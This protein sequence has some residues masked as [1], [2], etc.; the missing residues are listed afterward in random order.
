[1][2]VAG[3]LHVVLFGSAALL[4][5]VYGD[6]AAAAGQFAEGYA[7]LY[8]EGSYLDQV[9]FRFENFAA[10]RIEAFGVIP[11]STFLFLLG[12]RLMRSGAFSSDERG[13]RI[14]SRLL[15]W[16]FGLGVPLNLLAFL[17]N[18]SFELLT[19]YFFA[20]SMAL[21]YIGLAGWALERGLLPRLS[22]RFEEIGKMALS[23]YMLQNVLASAIFYGWGIG[24]TGR[25]GALG[26]LV[27]WAAVSASL[28]LFAHLWLQRFPNGPVEGV[29]K[30][31][32]SLAEPRAG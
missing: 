20:V 11:M 7:H 32:V 30:R 18:E 28:M 19:R 27:V 21:G 5:A 17:P 22:A 6:G 29:W 26:T 10:F 9:V 14:R 4:V 3:I 31:L 2:W 12:V 24:L 1:M 25:A 23:C 13:E 15:R 8:N 16:G